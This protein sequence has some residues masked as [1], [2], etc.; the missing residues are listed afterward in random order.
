MSC[1]G[2][3]LPSRL[4]DQ[5]SKA[6]LISAYHAFVGA[7]DLITTDLA[8]ERLREESGDAAPLE[9]LRA[10]DHFAIKRLVAILD[11]KS[12]QCSASQRPLDGRH[13]LIIGAG[14]GGLRTA[15]EAL[16]LGAYV[17]VAEKRRYMSRHNVLV[18]WK[19]VVDDL[20]SLGL[21][22]FYKQFGTGSSEKLCI[23]RLQ[24]MLTKLALI[25]GATLKI[26]C[27]FVGMQ[28]PEAASSRWLVHL[29]STEPGI[30]DSLNESLECDHLV[31]ADGEHSAVRE[32]V[33]FSGTL[34]SYSSSLG[35]TFNLA[36]GG[37]LAEIRMAEVS[38]VR[39]LSQAFF[40][41]L[42]IATGVRIEN[43]A[44]YKVLR[45]YTSLTCTW[46]PIAHTPY[47][48]RATCTQG[49]THYFVMATKPAAL[50]DA[51]ILKQLHAEPSVCVQRSN[52]D[53]AKLQA[54]ARAVAI[55]VGHSP[56]RPFSMTNRGEPDVSL[57]DFTA[58][59]ACDSSCRCL[60]ANLRRLHVHLVGDSAIGPFWP[61]G[62]G[63]N[64]AILG[65]F[66]AAYA[67]TRFAA[68]KPDASQSDV[69]ATLR[70][71]QGCFALLKQ[72]T[73]ASLKSC[74]RQAPAWRIDPKTRYQSVPMETKPPLSPRNSYSSLNG[75]DARSAR[76]LSTCSVQRPVD[77]EECVNYEIWD[78]SDK[79][80]GMARLRAQ[81]TA[82]DYLE[83]ME[84]GMGAMEV[85]MGMG[86]M[87][88]DVAGMWVGTQ[89]ANLEGKL[90]RDEAQA[91]AVPVSD[92]D[93]DLT[94]ANDEN[95]GPPVS[96]ADFWRSKLETD[97]VQPRLAAAVINV[98]PRKVH[99]FHETQQSMGKK[100]QQA[101]NEVSSHLQSLGFMQQQQQQQQ[102]PRDASSH[103][104]IEVP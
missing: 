51:G 93:I 13:V 11:L 37:S 29:R 86:E 96:L 20:Y 48:L 25:L 56:D 7:E 66:D 3:S 95:N 52:V 53:H 41:A 31:G 19:G 94:E 81:S 45:A 77:E 84:M 9:A 63:S 18:L 89:R 36:N 50:H 27:E 102:Q 40:A 58:K 82:V 65:A 87:G 92:N 103:S 80:R 21:K 101:I 76:R 47:K 22:E 79:P 32:H 97:E 64:R 70:E 42:D 73:T 54:F 55:F 24:L 78:G 83:A 68:L 4:Q 39:Y 10:V 43:L 1:T 30:E 35:I 62:T 72:S 14:P 91:P 2:L 98:R 49:E 15:I 33:G 88:M 60:E 61:L 85:D 8:F 75:L 28:R 99:Q 16:C 23:R 57:F 38:R 6:K 44:F 5:L 46:A 34:V 17:T 90:G 69:V 59:R 67:M 74:G 104:T 12:S 100:A 26:G 71:Q